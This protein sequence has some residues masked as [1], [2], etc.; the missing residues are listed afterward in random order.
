MAR[1]K[2]SIFKIL[3]SVTAISFLL[4][5][6]TGFAVTIPTYLSVKQLRQDLATPS[7]SPN[8]DVD[9]NG[10]LSSLSRLFW[11]MNAPV[12]GKILTA[13]DLNFG[14]IDSEI[15][16]VVAHTFILG[17]SKRPA[18][19]L[20]AFQNSAEARGV[21][22]LLGAYALLVVDK[23]T[24][25][26][27][28]TGSNSSLRTYNQIPISMPKEFL[29]LYGTNPADWR[30]SNLSPHFPYAAKIWL[31]LWEKQ[32]NEKLDGVI[33]MDPVA[34]SYLLKATGPITLEDG[35][36]ITSANVVKKTLVDAYQE[37]DS[38]KLERKP[39]LVEILNATAKR[40][41]ERKFSSFQLAHGIQRSI[42]ENRLLIYSRKSK[43]EKDLS[44]TLL[45]GSLDFNAQ[46]QF[47]AVV[48]NIDGS[49]LD[50]YLKR[51]VQVT[52]TQCSPARKTQVTVSITNTV[53]NVTSLPAYVLTRADRDKPA[54]LAPGQ[55]RFILFLYGPKRGELLDSYS[56]GSGLDMKKFSVERGRPIALWDIDLP[57]G[58]T[59]TVVANFENGWGPITWLDQPLVSPSTVLISDKC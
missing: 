7:N 38:S 15:K 28:R 43:V 4:V 1:I 31:G 35:E 41:E 52:S 12:T 46:N 23:G 26:I 53:R 14:S 40:I 3:A 34:I 19:Y 37:F 39:Y 47:R 32:F 49:K 9:T 24:V 58:Q 33:T 21:G 18:K 56:P 42:L 54:N 50:Y 57:P 45:G 11:V 55:H 27:E 48:Q 13:W 44:S 22:G 10:V 59:Q 29:N 20:V 5:I 51:S 6:A 36:Q 25:R 8:A 2:K 30:N 17:G 16:A